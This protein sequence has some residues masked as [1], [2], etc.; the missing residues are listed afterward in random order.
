MMI[1]SACSSPLVVQGTAEPFAARMHE[2]TLKVLMER[3]QSNRN[4]G[5]KHLCDGIV[6]AIAQRMYNEKRDG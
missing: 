1:R 3:C 6:T 5:R 4:Y 2:E